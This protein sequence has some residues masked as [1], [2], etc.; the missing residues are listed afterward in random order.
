MLYHTHWYQN[1]IWQANRMQMHHLL[2]LL[3]LL[4]RTWL[5]TEYYLCDNMPLPDQATYKVFLLP[6][7]QSFRLY[8]QAPMP[9][10]IVYVSSLLSENDI[11]LQSISIL[12]QS[13]KVVL[14]HLLL[15]VVASRVSVNSSNDFE[16]I[17]HPMHDQFQALYTNRP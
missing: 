7:Q 15:P 5:L 9:D 12:Y 17:S 1:S 3:P 11:R 8:K 6:R 2:Y 4:L 14:Y 16:W 10:H 13:V